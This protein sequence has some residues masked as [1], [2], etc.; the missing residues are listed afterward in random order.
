MGNKAK[1]L[2]IDDEQDLRE[3]LE[4]NLSNEGYTVTL[5]ASA[6]EALSLH[7]ED[8]DLL[9]LDVMMGGISGFKLADILR[10]E[11]KLDV[12]ILFLTAK[13]SENDLLTGFNVGGDDY[14]TKPY[15]VK[16]VLV[17]V[18]ALLKRSL[19]PGSPEVVLED[20]G[21]RIDLGA[22]SI[23]IDE[24]VVQLT[25]KEFD[26]LAL[27][28]KN[29]GKYI[30]R[31]EILDNIWDDDVIVTKRNVDVNITRLRKKI[32]AYGARIRSRTGFGYCYE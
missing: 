25:R 10:K 6:E 9:L 4:F 5:A 16:E 21:L 8:F 30:A 15:S 13:T 18:H 32:G 7:P 24:G 31:Q 19:R 1:I 12:P 22:K 17:R 23:V 28:L 3:I 27:L 20:D 29:R 14:L 26:I 11:K 2:V